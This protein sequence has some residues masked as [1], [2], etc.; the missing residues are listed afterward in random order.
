MAIWHLSGHLIFLW[1]FWYFCGHFGIFMA[2]LGYIFT[3]FLHKE[4]SGIL[5]L[6]YVCK[7]R[8]DPKVGKLNSAAATKHLIIELWER[9]EKL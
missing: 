6:L 7:M 3:I 8:A 9:L 4:I 1:T 2:I 5:G